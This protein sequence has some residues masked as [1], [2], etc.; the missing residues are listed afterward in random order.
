MEKKVSRLKRARRGRAKIRELRCHA[1]VR[2]SHAA[3]H[4]RAGRSTPEGA[5]GRRARRRCRRTCAEGL[6]GTGNIDAAK[7]VGKAIAERA[8]A[9]GRRRRSRST[10]RVSN[11]T[12]ASRRSPT[13]RAKPAS[14]SEPLAA[15]SR[16]S[17]GEN[18]KSRSG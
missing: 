15:G 3:A 13:P 1:P 14:S 6:K 10:V 7:A 17:N 8:K 18:R 11:I 16:S 2:A 5:R 12:A 4:L 9:D